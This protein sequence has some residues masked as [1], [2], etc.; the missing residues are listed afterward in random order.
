[1][2]PILLIPMMGIAKRFLDAGYIMPKPLI[3]VENNHIIDMSM[4]CIDQQEYDR[5]IFIVRS[6]HVYNFSID[7]ILKNKF[8]CEVVLLD[9]DTG[10]SLE[11]CTLCLEMLGLTNSIAPVVIYTPDVYFEPQFSV[12]DIID[13]DGFLLTFKANSPA[14]SYIKI[15]GYDSVIEVAEKR[16]IGN[17]ACV[18][19]YFI[20]S[21][22]LFY[23]IASEMIKN[24]EKTKNEF[25]IAPLY[26]HLIDD[27]LTV[28]HKCIEKMHVLGTPEELEFFKNKVCRNGD[29]PIALASDHSGFDLK[30]EVRWWMYDNGIKYIDYGTYSSNCCDYSDFIIQ[31]VNAINEG[32]C[33]IGFGFCRTGQ[34][35]NICA[36]KQ[37]GIFSALVFDK[38]TAE[39]AIRHNC[40]NFFS[41]PT[42]KVE[43]EDFFGIY[44]SICKNTF[45]GGRH[46]TR[47][48]KFTNE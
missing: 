27:G 20:K 8:N 29:K 2:K 34:G 37:N 23:N 9:N 38:Y 4:S 30:E 16:V 14:H 6:E 39:Y 48:R 18:G 7:K 25:Y 12:K 33:D 45:D 10:G 44:N 41:I 17:F 26:Q 1:M 43:L 42:F 21:I 31:A 32:I 24:N 19:V 36:N 11:T 13:S 15:N 5:I 47:I 3:M 40:A 46:M 22:K 35:V 28:S